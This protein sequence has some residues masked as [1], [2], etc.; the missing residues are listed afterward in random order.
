MFSRKLGLAAV[1]PTLLLAA[2]TV[3]ASPNSAEQCV[4][5]K[6]SPVAVAPYR[7]EQ[8]TGYGNYTVLRGAEVYV[9]AREGLTARLVRRPG[10]PTPPRQCSL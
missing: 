2:A 4:F 9:P 1:V 3:N 8:Y 5:D 7:Y 6:Y 10:G